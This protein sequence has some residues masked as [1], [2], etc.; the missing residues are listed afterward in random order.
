MARF[1]SEELGE[2]PYDPAADEKKDL[3]EEERRH[4]RRWKLEAPDRFRE[5]VRKIIAW[6]LARIERESDYV[7]AFWDDPAA[8]GGGTAAEITLAYRLGKPVY[9]VLGMPREAAS[10]WIL[11]ASTEVFDSFD[12]LREFLRREHEQAGRRET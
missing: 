3:N 1:L 12:Q 5:T 7:L 4:F 6:D 10:G 11:A 2:E 8:R 9:L